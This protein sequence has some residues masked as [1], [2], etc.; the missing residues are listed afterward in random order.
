M[1]ASAGCELCKE[2]VVEVASDAEGRPRYVGNIHGPVSER[3]VVHSDPIKLFEEGL[4][5]LPGL[6]TASGFTAQ[7]ACKEIC[8]ACRIASALCENQIR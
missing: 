8:M 1:R 7:V 3:G 4:Q 6:E 5:R 2:G